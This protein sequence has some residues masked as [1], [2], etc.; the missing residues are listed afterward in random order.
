MKN[1][2]TQELL[3]AARIINGGIDDFSEDGQYYIGKP[4]LL[5]DIFVGKWFQAVCSHKLEQYPQTLKVFT[6]FK[7]LITHTIFK[8]R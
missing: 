1:S 6:C 4:D 2:V 5:T 7:M 8:G 3:T